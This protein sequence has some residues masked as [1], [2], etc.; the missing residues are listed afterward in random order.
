M[1]V[2]YRGIN[3]S[4]SQQPPRQANAVAASD[5]SAQTPV[6]SNTLALPGIFIDIVMR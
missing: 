2:E 6:P 1:N 5:G 3:A 4:T